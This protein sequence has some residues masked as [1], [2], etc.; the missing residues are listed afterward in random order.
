MVDDAALVEAAG[1]SDLALRSDGLRVHRTSDDDFRIVDARSGAAV[2]VRIGDPSVLTVHGSTN[3]ILGVLDVALSEVLAVAGVAR[4]HASTVTD[5][6]RTLVLL[7]PSG[8]GKSTTTLRAVRAG[9]RPLAED[10]SF[11]EVETLLVHGRDRAIRLRPEAARALLGD[12]DAA[13]TE[14]LRH[15][16]PFEEM[17]GRLS[18]ARATHLV[19]LRRDDGP[20]PAWIPMS[21]G[22]TVMALFEASGVPVSARGRTALAAAFA[23]IVER[24]RNLAL[25]LGPLTSPFPPLP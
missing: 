14:D 24:T 11:V 10:G 23:H 12:F 3:G 2:W 21:R 7:G 9:W 6:S 1:A 19:H 5:G 22:D 20:I 18:C 16:V 13:A 25:T 8:R 17:E 4:L 15:E